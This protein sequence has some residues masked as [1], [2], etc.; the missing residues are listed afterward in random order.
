MKINVFQK[1]NQPQVLS[2]TTVSDW[3]ELIKSSEYSNDITKARNGEI[4]LENLKLQLPCVTYNFLYNKYKKDSNIISSTGFLFIDIDNPDFDINS[5]D[6]SKITGYYH[7]VGGTGYHIL[8]SVTGLTKQ[9]F[10]ESYITICNELGITKFI[11]TK[12]IKHSQFSIIS[13][14]DYAYYNDNPYVFNVGGVSSMITHH[15]GVVSSMITSYNT[16]YSSTTSNNI[17]VVSSMITDRE[18]EI[19]DRT[20]TPHTPIRFDNTDEISIPQNEDYVVDFDNGYEVIKSFLIPSKLTDNRYNTLLAYAT[21]LLYLNPTLSKVKFTEILTNTSSVISDTGIESSKIN[22]IINSVYKYQQEGKLT[23]IKFNKNRKIIFS[24]KSRLSKEEKLD[25]VRTELAIHKV[26]KSLA[27]IKDIITNWNT[28][29]QGT[30]SIKKMTKFKISHNTITKHLNA[31]PELN[32]LFNAKKGIS[33]EA[34]TDHSSHVN[35]FTVSTSQDDTKSLELTSN[36]FRTTI[37]NDSRIMELINRLPEL[38]QKGFWNSVD[39][40]MTIN[41]ILE[42]AYHI[43]KKQ[44]T[45]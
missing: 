40:T 15:I 16:T 33:T 21:N 44:E 11:D 7:S 8:I 2:S 1:V 29:E 30:I 36:D 6:K 13:Y 20:D 10:K 42:F 18:E 43:S 25:I 41:D 32:E 24:K 31:N 9:N 23:P 4:S 26:N 14:D 39:E 28:E 3:F 35:E 34:N 5:V 19:Y 17:R 38:T 22:R 37:E 45:A 27:K 12:A